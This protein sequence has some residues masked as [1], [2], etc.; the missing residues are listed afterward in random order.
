[1]A[2]RRANPQP[3][4]RAVVEE[5][6]YEEEQIVEPAPRVV[7]QALPT[8]PAPSR[9][10]ALEDFPEIAQQQ[11]AAQQSR[12]EAIASG[13]GGRKRPGFLERLSNVGSSL[14]AK[15]GQAPLAPRAPVARAAAPA[16]AP[17]AESYEDDQL[18]IPA[19][20]R[21]QAR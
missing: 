11:V 21:R 17:Q 14:G 18:A 2:P 4:Q 7:R 1:M 10:P 12:I 16:P 8:A 20:L 15:A 6:H 9:I 13:D 5:Q 3:I 19:F